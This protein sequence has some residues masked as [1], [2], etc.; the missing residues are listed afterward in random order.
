[1]VPAYLS[2]M[3][4]SGASDGHSLLV[5]SR[6]PQDSETRAQGR[7][8]AS[9]PRHGLFVSDKLWCLE[10]IAWQ[11]P[12]PTWCSISDVHKVYNSRLFRLIEP[13]GSSHLGL[14]NGLQGKEL[15]M[16]RKHQVRKENV[17]TEESSIPKEGILEENKRTL[18]WWKQIKSA[19]IMTRDWQCG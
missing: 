11:V 10:Q 2:L 9:G 13:R 8:V 7:H 4:A 5:D 18:H 12:K 6:R 14:D 15:F 19:S 1:M 16:P 17:H 3:S